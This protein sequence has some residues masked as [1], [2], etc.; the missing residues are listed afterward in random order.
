MS[1]ITPLFSM[2]MYTAQLNLDSMPDLLSVEFNEF[3]DLSQSS[4]RKTLAQAGWR[5]IHTQIVA[6]LSEFFHGYLRAAQGIELAVTDSWINRYTRGQA[7]PRHFHSN[8]V[9]SG[10]LMLCDHPST[11]SY[12]TPHRSNHRWDADQQNL[13]N[14]TSWSMPC[15][16]GLLIITPSVLD[17]QTQSNQT[18]QPRWTMAFDTEIQGDLNWTRQRPDN[19]GNLQI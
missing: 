14:S 10:V 9:F 4:D 12:Y 17:H 18:D 19:L 13:W 11:I 3:W 5:D 8:S 15:T 16:R 6:C 1:Q 7:Q 2:P